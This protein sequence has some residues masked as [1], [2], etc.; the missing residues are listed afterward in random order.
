MTIVKEKQFE[1]LENGRHVL[2]VRLQDTLLKAKQEETK[3]FQ[4]ARATVEAKF[5][6]NAEYQKSVTEGK[7]LIKS[8]EEAAIKL[9]LLQ[10]RVKEYE[11]VTEYL[12]AK[13][14]DLLELKKI[15]EVK[16][17]ELKKLHLANEEINAKRLQAKL[18]RD[19][20][21]EVKELIA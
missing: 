17:E 10:I 12:N 19:K 6:A 9:D 2:E 1:G 8:I 13:K 14:D 5:Q 21:V 4:E 16:N 7:E 15:G 3:V 18:N 20:N 11:D